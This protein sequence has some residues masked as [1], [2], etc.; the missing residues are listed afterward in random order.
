M[1]FPLSRL[2]PQYVLFTTS[3]N[4]HLLPTLSCRVNLDADLKKYIHP[5]SGEELASFPADLELLGNVKI[6]YIEMKGWQ[7]STIGAKTYYDLPKEAR[8]YM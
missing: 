1:I 2:R 7:K 5:E 6:K 3:L 4:L 8:D